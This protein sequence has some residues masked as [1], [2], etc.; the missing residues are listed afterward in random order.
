MQ[1]KKILISWAS[2]VLQR[3]MS[4]KWAGA[5]KILANHR[6]DNGLALRIHTE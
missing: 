4:R 6:S 5:Q 3:A 1:P 2:Y